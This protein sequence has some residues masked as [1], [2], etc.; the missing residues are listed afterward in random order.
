MRITTTRE[1]NYF[2]VSRELP[3]NNGY[4]CAEWG[5]AWDSATF[6]ATWLRRRDDDFD[7]I[8]VSPAL[9]GLE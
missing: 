4:A 7:A 3:Q 6:T 2:R 8:H 9:F 1:P 5:R